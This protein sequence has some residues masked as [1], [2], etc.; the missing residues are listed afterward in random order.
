MRNRAGGPAP[1][2]LYPKR[3]RRA[4]RVQARRAPPGAAALEER[5]RGRRQRVQGVSDGCCTATCLLRAG[6]QSRVRPGACGKVGQRAAALK[7][8]AAARVSRGKA[9]P[10]ALKANPERAPIDLKVNANY[11][12]RFGQARG[13]RRAGGG[14]AGVHPLHAEPGA[15]A[16]ATAA[17]LLW[18]P[19]SQVW[20]GCMA[21]PALCP[22]SQQR[23][24]RAAAGS[25]AARCSP[26]GL[27]PGRLRRHGL[28]RAAPLLV[29][30]RRQRAPRRWRRARRQAAPH[31]RPLAGSIP[32]SGKLN[33]TLPA[34]G[35]AHGGPGPRVRDGGWAGNRHHILSARRSAHGAAAGMG[36]LAERQRQG[37]RCLLSAPGSVGLLCER[38]AGVSWRRRARCQACGCCHQMPSPR[39]VSRPGRASCP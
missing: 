8:Y 23:P 13:P 37:R 30:H 25:L 10:Q 17:W 3:R 28:L 19:G 7:G 31:G 4:H 16:C 32:L 35:G 12:T 21:R 39:A 2:T 11:I 29:A 24:G 33:L 22:R 1:Y 5:R 9:A 34:A 20:L 36:G 15:R 18:R 6:M 26:H 27:P 38:E 14:R